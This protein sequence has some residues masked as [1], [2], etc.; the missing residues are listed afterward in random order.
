MKQTTPWGTTK[1]LAL[2]GALLVLSA[3]NQNPEEVRARQGLPPLDHVADADRGQPLF[4]ANCA[5]CHGSS[6]RGTDQGPPLINKIY[7]SGHHADF[8][9]YR[10][11]NDGVQQHHW[12]FGNMP[13][14]SAV[15]PTQAGDIV[16]WIRRE[17]RKYGIN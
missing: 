1:T 12:S 7:E 4:A 3:C 14:I 16:A 6:A 17:Q 13:A 15:T 9:F 11:I 10:A 8:A 5:G 2:A